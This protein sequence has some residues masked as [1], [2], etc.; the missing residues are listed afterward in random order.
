MITE[1]MESPT[2]LHVLKRIQQEL[3][4]RILFRGRFKEFF[5][6]KRV[7]ADTLHGL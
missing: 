7:P 5:D 2:N 1:S 3:V 6:Q 4:L